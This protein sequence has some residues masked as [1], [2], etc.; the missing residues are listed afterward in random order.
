MYISAIAIENFRNFGSGSKAFRL[1]L[2]PGLTAL[3]GENDA[4]KTA[5]TDALRLV[6]GTRDQEYFRVEASDF[7][8]P[9]GGQ[10]A[11]QISVRL[12]FSDLNVPDRA[13]FAEYLTYA[14]G[15]DGSE[16]S[17]I[18]TWARPGLD[19]SQSA[20]DGDKKEFVAGESTYKP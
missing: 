13:A 11:D 10:Q 6:L 2:K 20:G 7:H 14:Q 17:L 3:V 9:P 8:H 15:S 16:T 4:G 12:T 1:P 18:I 5:V 19:K